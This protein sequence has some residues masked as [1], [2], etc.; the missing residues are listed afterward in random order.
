MIRMKL[1][2]DYDGDGDV[3][4]GVKGEIEGLQAILYTSLQTY[5]KDKLGTPILYSAAAYPYFFIDTNA[6]GT[7]DADE[8]TAA[9]KYA[10]WTPRL[11]K[12]AYNLQYSI[13]DPGAYAHNGAYVIQ[14]LYDSIEDLG[15]DVTTLVRP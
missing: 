12:A 6:N 2:A 7:L 11:L 14:A 15:G 8:G 4:E 13:K 10:A 9:N 3:T 1:V 5:A